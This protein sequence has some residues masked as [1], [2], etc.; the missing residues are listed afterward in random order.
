MGIGAMFIPGGNDGLILF[1]IPSLSPHAIPAYLGILAG[2]AIA[3]SAM[4][5][6]GRVIPSVHCE[7]DICRTT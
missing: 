5:M 3:L 1:G 6:M 7:G 4:R 2:V